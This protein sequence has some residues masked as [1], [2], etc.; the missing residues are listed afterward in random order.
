MNKFPISGKIK[1]ITPDKVCDSRYSF[2]RPGEQEPNLGLP[3][4]D[5]WVLKSCADGIRYWDNPGAQGIQGPQGIQGIQGLQGAYGPA[6]KII[7]AVND[8]HA[9]EPA[10]SPSAYLE[11]LFF[12]N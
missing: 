10:L 11:S 9:G 1:T 6:I 8:V 5:G 2:M 3:V 4:C 7:G 12:W